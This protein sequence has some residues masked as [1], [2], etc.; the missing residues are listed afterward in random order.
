MI[1]P[2]L[3]LSSMISKSVILFCESS[4]FYVKNMQKYANLGSI[5]GFLRFI[6]YVLFSLPSL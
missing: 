5:P 1:E 3:Y 6:V 4:A 2:L